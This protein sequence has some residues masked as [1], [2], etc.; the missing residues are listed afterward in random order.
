MKKTI[1]ALAIAMLSTSAIAVKGNDNPGNEGNNGNGGP[2]TENPGNGGNGGA[3]G[4]GGNGGNGGAGGNQG[5]LQGQGQAQGQ[6]QGQIQGQLQG[7]AQGQGQA[8]SSFNANA[9]SNRNTNVNAN[10][11]ASFAGASSYS[12]GNNLSQGNSQNMTYNEANSMR[13]S[14]SYDVK[15]V[16]YAPDIIATP[17]S[18]CRISV[19]ASAGWMGGAFGFGGS[20]LDEGCDARE[21]SRTLWNVGEKEASIARLCQKTEMAKALGSKCPS[22]E[23]PKAVGYSNAAP[24]VVKDSYEVKYDED[25]RK[26][27]IF[28][29]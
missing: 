13:Y 5:Q 10:R 8:Q 17:T 23:E 21:D 25:T 22:T 7:Q 2:P 28:V 18:P 14:G 12:G 26:T 9:N 20:V 15:S 29:H 6:A 3:G 27:T 1:L 19:G 24:V 11:S 16:G 4:N